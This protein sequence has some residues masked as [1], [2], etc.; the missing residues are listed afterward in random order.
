[1]EP[2]GLVGRVPRLVGIDGKAKMSKSLGNAIYLKDDAETVDR[3]VMSMYTDPTRLRPTDPG[4][5]EGNPVFMYHDA[6]NPDA[7][8]VDDLKARYTRGAVGDVAVKRRLAVVINE[9]LR[10]IR[11]RRAYFAAHH[12]IAREA[13]DKG[14]RI[15]RD[16]GE[17]T[18]AAARKGL[19]LDYLQR[20]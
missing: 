4:R 7:D 1:V 19:R 6:F 17:R 18:M 2:E 14:S 16:V 13:L 5:V 8:E 15:A 3:K 9:L 11:E 12:R 10:P 20:D